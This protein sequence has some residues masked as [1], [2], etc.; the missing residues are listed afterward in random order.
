MSSQT[1]SPAETSLFSDSVRIHMRYDRNDPPPQP[2]NGS[3]TRFVCLSD[4]HSHRFQVPPGDVLLHSGDITAKGKVKDFELSMEWLRNMPHRTK[5]I[6]A[7]NHDL[8]LDEEWYKQQGG[9]DQDVAKVREFV[10]GAVA[11]EAGI[12]YLRDEAY[13]FQAKEGGRRWTVYGSPWTPY[14]RGKAFNYMPEDAKQIYGSIPN[15]DILMTHGPPHQVHDLT[16][17]GAHA[18]CPT[19]LERVCK[20]KPRLHL[21]GHIH[22]GRGATIHTW[23]RA[24]PKARQEAVAERLTA[25]VNAANSSRRKGF[26]K[27]PAAGSVGLEPVIVDLRDDA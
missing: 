16:M 27:R 14:F 26:G 3:W 9:A 11:K 10:S 6:I 20:I 17:D 21:F 25:F 24:R 19:N 22:E 4:T 5:I 2:E 12:V 1:L 18:G 13:E 7:G 15:V 8:T 23:D